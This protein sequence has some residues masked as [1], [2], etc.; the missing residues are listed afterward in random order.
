MIG[1][2]SS[3]VAAFSLQL[4]VSGFAASYPLPEYTTRSQR[5]FMRLA[6][7]AFLHSHGVLSL[8][9]SFEAFASLPKL[10][11]MSGS[12]TPSAGDEF[13]SRIHLPPTPSEITEETEI[14]ELEN[15]L[16]RM[17]TEVDSSECSDVSDPPSPLPSSSPNAYFAPPSNGNGQINLDDVLRQHMTLTDRL[18]PFWSRSLANRAVRLSVYTSLPVSG[19]SSPDPGR[20]PV[21]SI[22][23]HTSPQGS[24]QANITIPWDEIC[25]H[26]GAVYIAFGDANQEHE[27]FVHAE[28]LPSPNASL[29][30]PTP[31][32]SVS[33][34]QDVTAQSTLVVPVTH[35]QIRLIS[36]IDDTIKL[37]NVLGG[38][39]T[40]FRNV[41]VRHL[42]ELVIK[43][44]GDWYTNMWRRGVRF[45]YVV[46]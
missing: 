6:R 17:Q 38:A 29:A 10:P 4:F 16:R 21:A 36:D 19:S 1:V 40:I 25:V 30:A 22:V 39:R 27:L 24:F 43:G 34:I 26:P 42:E 8:T 9:V 7:G 2:C 41:F 11:D 3:L 12:N 28:L 18:Q 46:S 37:S 15:S 32:L 23:A 20:R 44:M 45:H 31:E 5:A 14:A 35:S 13:T 33:P